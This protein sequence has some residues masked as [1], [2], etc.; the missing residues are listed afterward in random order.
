MPRF[1]FGNQNQESLLLVFYRIRA[2][3]FNK[4]FLCHNHLFKF[5]SPYL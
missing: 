4:L 2:E 3:L 5:L 1:L